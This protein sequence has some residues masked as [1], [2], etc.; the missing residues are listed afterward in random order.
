MQDDERRDLAW[1]IAEDALECISSKRKKFVDDACGDDIDLRELVATFIDQPTPP[2]NGGSTKKKTR[3]RA[4]RTSGKTQLSGNTDL[5]EP[6]TGEMA[7]SLDET[8]I[9]SP[10]CEEDSDVSDAS[11]DLDLDEEESIGGYRIVQKL[12]EGGFGV[13]YQAIQEKPLRRDVAIKLLKPGMDSKQVIARFEAERQALA[14]MDHSSIA[15]VFDAGTTTRGRPYFVMELARGI[16]LTRF[17]DLQRLSIRQRIELF[18]EVCRA[19]QHAHH[20]GVIHRDIKPSN[21]L[22]VPGD[23][24]PKPVVIDFGVA[25]ATQQRLTEGTIATQMNQIIGTPLYMSPEQ[26]DIGG[27]D[28]DTRADIYSLGAVLYEL[29]SGRRPISKKQLSSVPG[30]E[31]SKFLRETSIRFPSARLAESTEWAE[32]VA[33]NRSSDLK[34]IRKEIR[35]ELDWIVLKAMD[36][37][38][39]RRYATASGLGIDLQRYLDDEP[40]GAHRPSTLYS[41]KKFT[42]RHRGPVVAGTVAFLSLA[43]GLVMTSIMYLT[44][45]QQ[46]DQLQRL[47]DA[48]EVALLNQQFDTLLQTPVDEKREAIDQWL[49]RIRLA[50]SRLDEHHD[51]LKDL[52]VFVDEDSVERSTDSGSDSDFYDQKLRGLVATLDRMTA[53]GGEIEQVARWQAMLPSRR[54]IE[55]GWK[56]FLASVNDNHPNWRFRRVDWLYPLGKNPVTGLWEFADLQL[57]LGPEKDESGQQR[58]T[59]ET[60]LVYVLLPGGTFKMGSPEDEKDRKQ[61]EKQHDVTVSP[62]LISKYEVTRAQWTR[63]GR[64]LRIPHSPDMG[65]AYPVAGVSWFDCQTFCRETSSRLPTE[66]EWEYA[67]RAGTTGPFGG[68]GVIREMGWYLENA[69][70]ELRPVGLKRPNDFGIYDMHGNA[71]EWC[72]DRY[73]NDFYEQYEGTDPVVD[74]LNPVDFTERLEGLSEACLAVLR[75]GTC[76]ANAKHCRSADRFREMQDIDTTVVGFRVCLDNVL[77]V[78]PKDE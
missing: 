74:P 4:G 24:K 68:T 35:G 71:S 7:T 3:V 42:K 50:A 65:P 46:A 55:E 30:Y 13:V 73:E 16:S 39:S 33:K 5:D 34:A 78:S 21:I 62:F 36:P 70:A 31:I 72:A 76:N 57:G 9:R 32:K 67:C 6:E 49:T 51:A 37:D 59:A 18:I 40:V 29:L 56:E 14:M 41:L 64:A 43:V 28:V 53:S 11:F 75:G 60:G 52:P 38:R 23:N 69:D 10:S 66:A 54:Q 12:G 8:L 2:K 26:A 27:L 58:M 47:S 20:K 63:V 22:V 61:D 25:K 15:K 19:I 45:L 1:S 77:T 48:G 17:C 44:A